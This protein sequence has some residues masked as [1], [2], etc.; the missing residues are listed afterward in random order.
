M[1]FN[2][3]KI[4]IVRCF[5]SHHIQG[6]SRSQAIFSP[7]MLGDFVSMED[8]VRVIDVFVD[9]FCIIRNFKEV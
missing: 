2:S 5:M 7:E 6:I 9:A 3:L 4:K 8:S 1:I